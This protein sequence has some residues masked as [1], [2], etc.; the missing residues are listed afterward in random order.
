MPDYLRD[1]LYRKVF[2]EDTDRQTEA[3][4]RALA[5][6]KSGPDGQAL[7]A[8]HRAAHGL[9]GTAALMELGAIAD[10]AARMEAAAQACLKAGDAGLPA[11][12]LAAVAADAQAIACLLQALKD[13][14]PPG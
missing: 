13:P 12:A 14:P 3:C 8:L 6:L 4:R 10:A 1:P 11:D 5:A 2:F 7:S 9:K